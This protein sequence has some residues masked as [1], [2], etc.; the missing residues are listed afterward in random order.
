[1]QNQHVRMV[2]GGSNP[3][4]PTK[5]ELQGT[6]VSFRF[7]RGIGIGSWIGKSAKWRNTVGTV[8]LI[9]LSAC[10]SS[11]APMTLQDE[12]RFECAHA[13]LRACST[14]IL[15]DCRMDYR[16][17]CMRGASLRAEQL[18]EMSPLSLPSPLDP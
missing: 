15:H 3:P 11:Q 7:E 6:A 4:A 13:A 12:V 8:A 9:A 16:R 14:S 1:M 17:Q 2:V 5:F 18:E 10:A